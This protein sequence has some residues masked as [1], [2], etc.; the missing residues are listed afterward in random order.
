MNLK[1]A[2]F[3]LDAGILP[4]D[5]TSFLSNLHPRFCQEDHAAT[6]MS[7]PWEVADENWSENHRSSQLKHSV[8]SPS[9]ALNFTQVR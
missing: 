4:C 6:E 3:S 5:Y 7:L 2:V 1:G 9:A 8:N